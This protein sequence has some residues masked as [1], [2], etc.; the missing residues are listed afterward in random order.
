MKKFR[1]PRKIK[2]T[3]KKGGIFLY[4][5]DIETKTY[6]TAWPTKNQEDYDAYKIELLF[7][8]LDRIKSRYK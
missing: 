1:L 5:M 2:K 7:G 6:L 4:P 8:L 3:I